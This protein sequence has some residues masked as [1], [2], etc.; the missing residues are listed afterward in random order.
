MFCNNVVKHCHDWIDAFLSTEAAEDLQQCR[1]L[2][3]VIKHLP[4]LKIAGEAATKTAPTPQVPP[5][6]PAAAPAPA[7]TRTL[8][9]RR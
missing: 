4:L 2:A 5:A 9:R 7:S 6:A 3:G 8:R 1:T